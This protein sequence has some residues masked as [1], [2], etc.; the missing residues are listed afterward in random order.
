LKGHVVCETD[1]GFI[2]V[3]D[4]DDVLKYLAENGIKYHSGRVGHPDDNPTNDFPTTTTPGE[5][6]R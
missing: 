4:E 5:D 2:V 1:E 6:S 3:I